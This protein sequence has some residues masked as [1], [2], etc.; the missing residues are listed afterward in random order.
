LI[1]RRR[2]L[3]RCVRSL[4]RVS[5]DDGHEILVVCGNGYGRGRRDESDEVSEIVNVLP[6]NQGIS[7]VS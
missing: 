7:K 3:R 6:A 5:G 2:I 1:D 4:V